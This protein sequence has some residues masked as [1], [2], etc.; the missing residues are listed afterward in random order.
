[1]QLHPL[2]PGYVYMRNVD[3]AIFFTL[4][5]GGRIRPPRPNFTVTSE[6]V[7]LNQWGVKPPNPPTN[8]TLCTT[9]LR[10]PQF[11]YWPHK[12]VSTEFATT[13]N[14]YVLWNV[15]L[16]NVVAFH[17]LLSKYLTVIGM[18]LN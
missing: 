9:K 10:K 14:K 17:T 3:V 8:R 7:V 15:Y 1:M 2:H 4:L 5:G 13:R 18:T 6:G 12:V 16:P 11:D